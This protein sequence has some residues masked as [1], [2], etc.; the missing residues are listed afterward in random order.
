M[1]DYG[2]A[3][4]AMG[5][6]KDKFLCYAKGFGVRNVDTGEAVTPVSLFHMASVSKPFVATAILQL[7]ERG[8]V[9]LD[10][11]VLRYLPYF[12]LDDPRAGAITLRQM[13]SHSAGMPD[14][15]DY[16][17]YAPEVDEGAL[18]RYVRTLAGEKLLYEPGEDHAYSNAAFEVLG[19]V[20]A[21]VSGQSFEAYIKTNILDPLGMH[22]STFLRHEVRP[23]LATTPH[24]GMPSTTLG[25]AYPYHRAHAPS[26]TL[27]SNVVEMSRWAIANLQHGE[28]EGTRILQAASHDRLWQREV[29]TDETGWEEAI[30]LGWF[31]GTYGGQPIVYHDGSD[32]GFESA[33][34]LLPDR[35]DAVVVMGN[36]NAA[37]VAVATDAALDWLTGAPTN[38]RKPP[39]AVP[40]YRALHAAGQEAAIAT[41]R[42]LQTEAGESFDFRPT[43]FMD[44]CWGAIETHRAE[45]VMELLHLWLALQPEA[46]EAHEMMGWAHLVNG[47]HE[48][49]RQ[50]LVRA[51]TLDPENE[52]AADL[53]AQLDA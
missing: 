39:A 46:T 14:A 2:M 4:L 32:P 7:A 12:Q 22:D 18:E 52:H 35:G 23:D 31:F 20:I 17:W 40:V 37:G 36:S 49:A 9:E 41:Y 24:F 34:V 25:D 45:A 30:G 10:A 21:K 26:S 38:S 33:L 42:R 5:I 27:H 15:V 43:R 6:V 50:H 1:D 13:L 47:D 3:G 53:L 11:P 28:L 51:L 29:E 19:D 44:F 16:H 48:V 8:L